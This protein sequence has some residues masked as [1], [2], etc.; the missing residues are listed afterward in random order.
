MFGSWFLE[1]YVG[2][3]HNRAIPFKGIVNIFQRPLD[4]DF[5]WWC[6]LQFLSCI[7]QWSSILQLFTCNML[8]LYIRSFWHSENWTA[9]VFENAFEVLA[10]LFFG[11]FSFYAKFDSYEWKF[12]HLLC[13][14]NFHPPLKK[15]IQPTCKYYLK[16]RTLGKLYEFSPKQLLTLTVWQTG[17]VVG[18]SDLDHHMLRQKPCEIPPTPAVNRSPQINQHC[19]SKTSYS[20]TEHYKASILSQV[21]IQDIVHWPHAWMYSHTHAHASCVCMYERVFHWYTTFVFILKCTKLRELKWQLY[22]VQLISVIWMT[23]KRNLWK[24]HRNQRF[25]VS[26]NSSQPLPTTKCRF[27]CLQYVSVFQ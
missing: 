16:Y 17:S 19:N 3:G 20:T 25:S 27:Q 4:R 11:S 13:L 7:F 14:A 1:V 26:N 9:F 24:I 18:K 10:L 21:G 23:K 22:V 12:W 15:N 5:L 8:I 6:P 2:W